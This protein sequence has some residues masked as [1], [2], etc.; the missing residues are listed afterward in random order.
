MF[1]RILLQTPSGV[2][3]N[4]DLQLLQSNFN[5]N[6]QTSKENIFIDTFPKVL[7]ENYLW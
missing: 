3:I 5:M 4:K 6:R 2:L 7:S 1:L